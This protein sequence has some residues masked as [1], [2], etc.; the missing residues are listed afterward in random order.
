MSYRLDRQLKQIVLNSE[1]LWAEKE[2]ELELDLE[3]YMLLLTK[4]V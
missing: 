1:P 2:I 4:K 3:K